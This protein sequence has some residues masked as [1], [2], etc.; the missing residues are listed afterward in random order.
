[1][2]KIVSGFFISLD[3]VVESPDKWHFPYFN[4][5]MGE[6]IGRGMQ[7][8]DAMLMGRKLYE[9]WSEY[10]PAAGDEDPFGGF[11]N[12]IQKYVVST[13]LDK[14][15]WNNTTVLNGDFVEEITNLKSQPGKDINISGSPTLV[16]SLLT[17]GLLDELQLLIHP[18]IVGAGQRLFDGL[19]QIPLKVVSSTTLQ[20]GVLS[21]LY[22]PADK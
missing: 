22:A 3:G 14:A 1:M 16:R 17:H 13:T 21:V 2:R 9:E 8:A 20:T 10:W 6:V 15:D 7:S 12:N 19:D 11:I 4:D 18:I 5:E